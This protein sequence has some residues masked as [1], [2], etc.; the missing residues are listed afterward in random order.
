MSKS[1]KYALALMMQCLSLYLLKQILRF[2]PNLYFQKLPYADLA[3]APSM[4][5]KSM[6]HSY[7]VGRRK[8]LLPIVQDTME[9]CDSVVTVRDY[10]T[11][12]LWKSLQRNPLNYKSEAGL[13]NLRWLT[14]KRRSTCRPLPRPRETSLRMVPDGEWVCVTRYMT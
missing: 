4:G 9:P 13:H 12:C 10:C 6:N 2:V 14:S 7:F 8:A 1:C 11:G 3:I 5:L